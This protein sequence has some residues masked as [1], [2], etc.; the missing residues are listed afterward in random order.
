LEL[1]LED[2]LAFINQWAAKAVELGLST[3]DVFGVHPIAPA[4]RFDQMGLVTVIAG[5]RVTEVAQDTAI[6]MPPGGSALT[7]YR[8]LRSEGAYLWHRQ[9]PQKGVAA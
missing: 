9:T 6:I 1:L 5:G 7:Y 2:G 3:A 8:R 4:A